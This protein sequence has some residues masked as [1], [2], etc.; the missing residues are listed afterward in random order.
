M[1]RFIPI[2][3]DTDA[4]CSTP[5]VSLKNMNQPTP[6]TPYADLSTSLGIP[7]AKRRSLTFRTPPPRY[8]PYHLE[9]QRNSEAATSVVAP[10]VATLAQRKSEERPITPIGSL[11]RQASRTTFTSIWSTGAR[12]ITSRLLW[13]TTVSISMTRPPRK[14]TP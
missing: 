13:S 1:D 3:P 7:P 9:Y 2:R 11:M 4:S 8:A 5:V 14:S 10:Y 6:T 12:A